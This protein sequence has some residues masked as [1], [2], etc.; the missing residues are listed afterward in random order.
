MISAYITSQFALLLIQEASEGKRWDG[1]WSAGK[2][3]ADI[4][5]R[6]VIRRDALTGVICQY[7]WD[8][9]FAQYLWHT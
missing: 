5:G 8:P 6:K 7:I 1:K 4:T 2:D 3:V 9:A